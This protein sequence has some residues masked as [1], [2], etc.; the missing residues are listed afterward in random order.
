[1]SF[2]TPLCQPAWALPA[3]LIAL[4]VL[5][6]LLGLTMWPRKSLAADP[7]AKPFGDQPHMPA[8]KVSS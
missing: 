6:V 4:G 2:T 7:Y 3:A 1:V 5:F 8:D